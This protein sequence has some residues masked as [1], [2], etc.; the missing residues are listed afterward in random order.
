[1]KRLL[2]LLLMVSSVAF[3]NIQA[4]ASLS[5]IPN[6][7][8]PIMFTVPEWDQWNQLGQNM[9][10]TQ[11]PEVRLIVQGFGGIVFIGNTFIR[12]MQAAQSKGL[13]VDM[14]VVGPVY[15]LHAM[16]ICFADNLMIDEGVTLMYH[17][18]SV[19]TSLF[20][21]PYNNFDLTPDMQAQEQYFIDAC[22]NKGILTQE[23]IDHIKN[24][25]DVY[26]TM[27]H[28]VL[29]RQYAPDPMNFTQVFLPYIVEG[30][31]LLVILL[32]L[33]SIPIILIRRRK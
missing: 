5:N 21:I 16:L 9:A 26:I 4:P 28:G 18:I 15:S 19:Q 25:D 31:V 30:S 2:A 6:V 17:G 3:A 7:V 8:V 24:K 14:E 27:R 33:L 32:G 29:V 23:D 20:G 10:T 12:Q 22:V 13:K 1:M 11:L